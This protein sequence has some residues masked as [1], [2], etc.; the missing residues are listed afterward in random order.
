MDEGQGMG[1]GE[2]GMGGLEMGMRVWV[3]EGEV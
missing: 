2:W 3:G 1:D